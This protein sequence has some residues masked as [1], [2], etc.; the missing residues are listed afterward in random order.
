MDHSIHVAA[1]SQ[2]D[3][4]RYQKEKLLV[5]LSIPAKKRA[6]QAMVRTTSLMSSA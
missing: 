3:A 2:P 5:A 6:K 4:S 1:K